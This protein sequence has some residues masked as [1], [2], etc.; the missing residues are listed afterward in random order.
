[1]I[2]I[3]HALPCQIPGTQRSVT[4]WHFGVPGS[5]PK[6]YLQAG[7]HADEW[8]PMLVA[9][10][11]K[12]QLTLLED[13]GAI[14]GEIVLVPMV[15]P[16]GL[17]QQ[18]QGHALGRFDLADGRNFNRGYPYLAA[19][20][21]QAVA[22]LL[23]DDPAHNVRVMRSAVAAALQDEVAATEAEA[24]KHWA[25]TQAAD[26]DIVLDLHCDTE[27]VMHVY[28]G[29]PNAERGLQLA[30]LL[31]AEALIV[32]VVSGDHPFD[33]ALARIWWEAAAAFAGRFPLPSSCFAATVEL[34]GQ[35]D[36]THAMAHDD[37]RNLLQFLALQGVLR[38]P[39]FALPEA[40]CAATPLEAVEPI[41]ATQGGLVVHLKQLGQRVAAGEPII[42]LIDPLTD[43]TH[44]LCA[45]YP[46]V[47]FARATN[48]FVAAGT[49]LAKIAG[50]TAFRS[51][52]L[53]SE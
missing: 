15:N 23:G 3:Q 20:V 40:R 27:A 9:H 29:T 32:S 4:S 53:L 14:T 46:G 11:L 48:R 36:M 6:A 47:L 52:P 22:P 35:T 2:S 34:R 30:R 33:E 16:I 13:A 5:G 41:V 43:K 21:Q 38:M 42:E 31:H 44:T 12:Q 18:W 10:H 8:P 7:L 17:S 26:A 19:Q 37:A 49:R 25:M 39:P 1:M 24:L 45:T 28:T 50:T 51:G